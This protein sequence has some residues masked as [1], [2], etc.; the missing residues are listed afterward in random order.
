LLLALLAV[1]LALFAQTRLGELSDPTLWPIL[2]F[3]LAVVCLLTADWLVRRPAS[4]AAPAAAAEAAEEPAP[5]QATEDGMD[6]WR[7][8]LTALSVVL[9]GWVIS[10]LLPHALGQ[11]ATVPVGAWLLAWGMLLLAWVRPPAWSTVR[12][13]LAA[14]RGEVATVAAITLAAAG[15]RLW[16]LG[17]LPYNISGDEGSIGLEIRRVLEGD[18]RNPFTLAW[19]PLPTMWYFVQAGPPWLFGLGPWSLRLTNAL[20]GVLAVPMLYVLGRLLFNRPTALAAALLLAGY[21]LHLHYSRATINVIFDTFFYPAALAA[22]VYGL[23]YGKGTGAFVLAGVLAG[24]AQYTNV[25]ARLLPLMMLV[26]VLLLLLLRR[27]WLRGRGEHMA[28]LLLAFGLV[29]GPIIVYAIQRPDDYNTRLNQVGI[30]QAGWLEQQ[31][32]A[33][34]VGPLPLLGEQFERTLFGFAVYDDRTVSYG[35]GPLANPAMALLLF[36]GLGLSALNWR[37]PPALLLSLWFWAGLIGGGVLTVDPPTSNRLVAIVPVVALLAGLALAEI[38]RVLAP[39]LRRQAAPRV[40]MALVAVVALPLALFD[41]RYY[42]GDY[43]PTHHFGGSHAYI[44]TTVGRDLAD[45]PAGTQL[46]F[47]GAPYMWSGFST[48]RFLAPQLERTDVEEPLNTPDDLER[49]IGNADSDALFVFLP[50]RAEELALVQQ[51]YPGGEILRVPTPHPG[52]SGLA[53]AAYRVPQAALATHP[54]SS[55]APSETA[56]APANPVP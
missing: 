2:L 48:L 40:A 7:I 1:L 15:L 45:A 21:Q 10:V 17:S 54:P 13:W 36:L 33:R 14:N 34:N 28:A 27:D 39:L 38:A 55:S 11:D 30:V 20:F 53:F 26:F 49:L 56:T 44:A 5:A 47:F 4:A 12:A 31:Q 22:L 52:S 9:G 43:L 51:R 25:G 32:E 18:M 29:A 42:F 8:G 16:Q 35:G 24:L 37:H 23:R 50:H 3:V 46:Y 41:V 6:Y 19:G